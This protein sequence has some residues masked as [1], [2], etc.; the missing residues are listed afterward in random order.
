MTFFNNGSI[1][2]LVLERQVVNLKVEGSNPSGTAKDLGLHK[3][4]RIRRKER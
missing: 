3:I 4:L 1:A 2:Q